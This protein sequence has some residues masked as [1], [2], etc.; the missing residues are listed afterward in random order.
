MDEKRNVTEMIG[1]IFQALA[2]LI[3]NASNP[4]YNLIAV[5]IPFF[6]P[7]VIAN[8]VASALVRG[9]IVDATEAKYLAF[10]LEGIGIVGLAGLVLAI[11]AWIKSKNPK[12]EAMIWLLSVID[13]VYFLFLVSV[14]V[15]LDAG[16]PNV[17]G[18]QTFT[19]ALICLVPLMASGVFGYH[20]MQNK[21]KIEKRDAKQEAYVMRQEEREDRLKS[22]AM[23]HGFNP[24][25]PT[26][27]M[28][29]D[30]PQ[31]K[32]KH[33]SDYKDSVL[34]LLDEEFAKSGTVLTPATITERINKKHRVNLEHSKVKGFWTRTTQEWRVSRGK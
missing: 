26:T 32:V 20:R 5:T 23:K 4:I 22:K 1:D 18:L 7:I 24:F 2:D 3:D 16:N 19:R 14:V 8:I 27:T 6:A 34:E 21:D 9:Q 15:L 25:S 12:T 10:V 30:T 13:V 11:D 28:N 31:V 29:S 33:A 17:T